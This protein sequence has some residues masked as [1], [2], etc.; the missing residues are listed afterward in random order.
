MLA[1]HQCKASPS[2]TKASTFIGQTCNFV[3]LFCS[4]HLIFNSDDTTPPASLCFDCNHQTTKLFVILRW[5]RIC[6]S[7][8]G[9]FPLPAPP[10]LWQDC[11]GAVCVSGHYKSLSFTFMEDE[12]RSIPWRSTS[13]CQ[14]AQGSNFNLALARVLLTD[15]WFMACLGC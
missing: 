12:E 13:T 9:Q 4:S 11:D 6:A 15:S 10:E 3:H 7:H 14:C 2:F 1:S 8:K 5:S